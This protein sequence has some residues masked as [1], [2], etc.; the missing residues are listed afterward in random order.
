M[1]REHARLSTRLSKRMA[2]LLSGA[3]ILTLLWGCG[4][5]RAQHNEALSTAKREIGE[6]YMRQG[7]YTAALRELMEAE[8]LNPR[9]PLVHDA[10]GLCYMARKRMPEAIT[11]FKRAVELKPSFTAARNNLG[12]AY[13]T[14]G[15]WDA[16]IDIFQ[17]IKQDVLY[18]TPQYAYSN[19]GWAHYNKQEYT[20][21]LSYYREALKLQQDLLNALVGMGRT[22]LALNQGRQAIPHLEKARD[23]SPKIA[24]I[25]FLLG[26]AYLLTGQG[27]Q[28]R[29][30]YE[31]ALDLAPRDSEVAVKARQRLGIR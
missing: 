26:E 24:E 3:L 4:G 15:E 2:V 23:M 1:I 14:V 11:H 25:H 22:H 31:T 12:A 30:A 7:N 13:M 20:T 29:T 19:L 16:A 27:L 17:E 21:A 9:D 6:A 18:A 28:A 10:L 8:R 5:Q